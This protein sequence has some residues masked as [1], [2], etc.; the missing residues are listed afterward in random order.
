M[1][2]TVPETLFTYYMT[3][4]RTATRS[5]AAAHSAAW[6]EIQ[7]LLERLP[8]LARLADDRFNDRGARDWNHVGSEHAAL[9]HLAEA[10]RILSEI[11]R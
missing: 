4:N 3:T 5:A 10:A 11:A 2:D 6:A 9:E 1:V 8:E 7:T